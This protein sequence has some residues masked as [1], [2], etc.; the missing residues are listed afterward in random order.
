MF[1]PKETYYASV[2]IQPKDRADLEYLMRAYG[3]M[4]GNKLEDGHKAFYLESGPFKA[5]SYNGALMT[6]S[7]FA[8]R[9]GFRE[10]SGEIESVTICVEKAV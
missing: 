9:L 7:L 8:K 2:R 10:V 6:A 1:G 3:Y 4:A 5:R